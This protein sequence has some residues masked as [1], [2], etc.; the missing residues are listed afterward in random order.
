LTQSTREIDRHGVPKLTHTFGPAAKKMIRV[1]ERLHPGALTDA[2][3]SW[4]TPRA[5]Q[6][7]LAARVSMIA[8]LDSF[9][10]PIEHI[11]SMSLIHA[12]PRNKKVLLK[13]NM[14]GNRWLRQTR[15]LA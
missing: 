10:R 1:G 7:V 12:S 4:L 14:L 9:R 11:T 15:S 6:D 5:D 13:A 2:Q 8:G 3:V